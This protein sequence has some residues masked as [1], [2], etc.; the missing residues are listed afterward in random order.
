MEKERPAYMEFLDKITVVNVPFA[1]TVR[2]PTGLVTDI[3]KRRAFA[4]S[5]PLSGR[6]VY[7]HDGE[8]FVSDENHLTLHPQGESYN[9]RCER[10]GEFIVID[11]YATRFFTN[12]FHSFK[13]SHPE[14]LIERYHTIKEAHASGSRA[15]T[16]SE[17]YAFIS[18]ISSDIEHKESHIL[19]PALSYI[20]EHLTDDAISNAR[21][22]EIAHI[23][24]SYLR[25]LFLASL[26]ETPRQYLIRRRLDLAKR[27]L[28]ESRLSV[29]QVAERCGFSSVYHFC[30]S[31]KGATGQTPLG[32]SKRYENHRL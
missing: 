21:L 22:A 19:A 20:D 16:L 8:E 23:S 18:A 3:E 31:F 27:L 25:R 7:T 14:L 29:A 28:S 26:G 9:L 12:K 5:L 32:Y 6:I 10:A 2:Q 15:R 11:F 1:G 30:R 13:I 17:F 24:E 4:F